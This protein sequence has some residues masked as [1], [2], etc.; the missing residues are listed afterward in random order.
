MKKSICRAFL[1]SATF[2]LM[3]LMVQQ[4][5]ASGY[6]PVPT[7]QNVLQPYSAIP[8]P[9]LHDVPGSAMPIGVGPVANGSDILNITVGL[10]PFG[11][12]ATP[13]SVDIYFGLYSTV[14]SQD[15]FFILSPSGFLPFST[16]GWVKWLANFN[17]GGPGAASPLAATIIPPVNILGTL[18]PGTYYLYLLVTP[19]SPNGPPGLPFTGWSTYFTRVNTEPYIDIVVDN[20][21]IDFGRLDDVR[22]NLGI[23]PAPL[24]VPRS[25]PVPFPNIQFPATPAIPNWGSY[26]PPPVF[27]SP[28]IPAPF[29]SPLCP[30]PGTS[31][32]E[33]LR[34]PIIEGTPPPPGVITNHY[35][36]FQ[37][38]WGM[39]MVYAIVADADLDRINLKYILPEPIMGRGNLYT[40]I[41]IP[42]A[43]DPNASFIF[44][45]DGR[46]LAVALPEG[47]P[48]GQIIDNYFI[49]DAYNATLSLYA[50][51]GWL[52]IQINSPVEPSL[53]GGQGP[54]CRRIPWE[55]P[56]VI[57]FRLGFDPLG[58]GIQT[59]DTVTEAPNPN[60]G[61]PQGQV[62]RVYV[63]E[64][65][66]QGGGARGYLWL[67]PETVAVDFWDPRHSPGVPTLFVNGTPL[68]TVS[69]VGQALPVI[70]EAPDDPGYDGTNW[71]HDRRLLDPSVIPRGGVIYLGAG[72]TDGFSPVKEEFDWVSYPDLWVN[73]LI[74]KTVYLG[75]DGG[76]SCPGGDEVTG[77]AGDKITYCFEVKNTGAA[78]LTQITINDPDLGVNESYLT[79]SSGD[80]PLA[81]GSSLFYYLETQ[82][83]G[84]INNTATVQATPCNSEGDVFAGMGIV[85]HSDSAV[86][87][88]TQ[89]SS[90][91]WI[92]LNIIRTSEVLQENQEEPEEYSGVWKPKWH[93]R[94]Y[95]NG[96][97]YGGI[98]DPELHG[99]GNTSGTMTMIIDPE[100]SQVLSFSASATTLDPPWT[101]SWGITGG[102]IPVINETAG[103]SFEAK[104]S[105]PSL[106]SQ[107]GI[108]ASAFTANSLTDWW[109][110]LI[111]VECSNESYVWIKC[112]FL[113]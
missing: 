110:R 70:W 9:V 16:S 12:P 33:L 18:P 63:E 20:T 26:W 31:S 51:R 67:R 24:P 61:I 54:Y 25:N 37:N 64:G 8:V 89:G 22:R 58:R 35:G 87:R 96:N 57:A 46:S 90:Y 95:F 85:T 111:R 13:S 113:D 92:D 81:P 101:S 6:L 73:V 44:L 91:C 14:F 100:S 65:S 71:T 94:G 66:W 3:I 99:G 106:C 23:G 11:T 112:T 43:N 42:G 109:D 32:P 50:S 27:P 62:L 15:D 72:I 21:V 49:L 108:T 28:A 40:A 29:I 77:H 7:E 39:T 60:G 30:W 48:I 47:Y 93:A 75:W 79:L 98:I 76:S 82:I 59:N 36:P 97:T 88:E 52:P 10:N 80:L 74:E 68:A 17:F 56:Y 107:H 19:A 45:S 41:Q 103:V 105:G 102:N 5:P 4:N 53:A 2:F 55:F 78:H 83:A 38:P 1:M 34:L 84:D 104:V 69:Y 86:V